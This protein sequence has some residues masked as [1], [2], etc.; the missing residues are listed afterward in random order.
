[1]K[2]KIKTIF[3][4]SYQDTEERKMLVFELLNIVLASISFTMSVVNVITNE[5]V[6]FVITASYA[7]LCLINYLFAR[8]FY[9]TMSLLFSLESIAMLT[10]F[11]ITG[12]PQGFSVLWTLLIPA[13]SLAIFGKK[14]GTRFCVILFAVIIFFFWVPYGKSLLQWE[15]SKTFMLRF[16]FVYI[17]LY[18]ISF[19]IEWIR[20]KTF[21]KLID[22]EDK[23][24]WLYRHDALTGIFNRYA[25]DEEL[26][27]IFEE[28]SNHNT[29]ILMCDID[30]FK[31]I[32]DRYGHN[33]GD[34]VL[35][36][37]AKIIT[38]N[39]CEHCVACRWG[40]EEFLVVMRCGHDP[41]E[42]AEKIHNSAQ[43]AEIEAEDGSKMNFTVSIGVAGGKML[44]KLEVRNYIN[45]ADKAMYS[46]KIN[47]KN[48]IT[49]ARD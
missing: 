43:A 2:E 18:L 42:V 21:E 30:E 32:N 35:K 34:T 10:A 37:A 14:G 33:S 8:R 17:C 27:K 22:T 39:I 44:N 20:R 24:R 5:M 12:I 29:S 15:Y 1:M 28:R 11:I 48:G 6:L 7:F 36:A 38:E 31:N 19:Y 16:P 49:D 25:F 41:I 26:D 4:N 40:G 46:S 3:L 47:G 9:S 23:Y 45:R 13:C